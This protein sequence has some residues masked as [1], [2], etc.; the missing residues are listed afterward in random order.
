M[1]QNRAFG[2]K[3]SSAGKIKIH[4]GGLQGSGLG[5]A[6]IDIQKIKKTNTKIIVKT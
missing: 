1:E 2:K 6:S 5:P 4:G 3:K